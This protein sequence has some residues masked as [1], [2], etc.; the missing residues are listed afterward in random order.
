M[1]DKTFRQAAAEWK[2]EYAEWEAGTHPDRNGE[3]A[4]CEFWEYDGNPP[5]PESYRHRDWTPEEA[6]GYQIYE[7][8]S[9]GTPISPIFTSLDELQEWLVQRGY[10]P[11]AA[12]NFAKGGWA[13]SMIVNYNPPNISIK[14]GIEALGDEEEAQP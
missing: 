13:P 5:D 4:D 8:V 10:S 2:A 1:F 9:E 3:D 14:V 7:D 6:V 12:A 11:S